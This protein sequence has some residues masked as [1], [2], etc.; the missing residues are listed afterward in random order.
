MSE[1]SFSQLLERAGLTK[2][3]LARRLDM[4]PRSMTQWGDTAPGYAVAYLEL[5][6]RLSE[7][8]AMNRH[9]F[10]RR[11]VKGTGVIGQTHIDFYSNGW[12]FI[13]HTWANGGDDK[14]VVS[15]VPE[16]IEG[17]EL[18]EQR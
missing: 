13:Q 7:D 2:A 16:R 17:Y 11:F 6:I 15:S 4:N 9:N 14:K 12:Q 10:L 8:S 3:E 18:Y 1:K 5:W